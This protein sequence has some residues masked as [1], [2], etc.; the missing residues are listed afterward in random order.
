MLVGKYSVV[1]KDGKNGRCK[2]ADNNEGSYRNVDNEPSGPEDCAKQCDKFPKCL[3]FQ[4]RPSDGRCVLYGTGDD[5]PNKNRGESDPARTVKT[6]G[7]SAAFVCYQRYY[8]P[9][10]GGPVTTA[11]NKCLCPNGNP[12]S[13]AKCPQDRANRCET[14]NPGFKLDSSGMACVGTLR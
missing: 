9:E 2:S 1:L 10:T 4:Y 8:D 3:A 13:G 6:D 12:A 5:F 14:C 7:N 11:P